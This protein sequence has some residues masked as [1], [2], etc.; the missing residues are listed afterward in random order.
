[1]SASEERGGILVRHLTGVFIALS[2][3]LRESKR[4][5]IVLLLLEVKSGSTLDQEG[6]LG[7]HWNKNSR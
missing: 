6:T 7:L 1:M 4:L 2:L 5:G 3:G